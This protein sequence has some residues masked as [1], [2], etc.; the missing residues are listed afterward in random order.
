M[1]H[2]SVTSGDVTLTTAARDEAKVKRQTNIALLRRNTRALNGTGVKVC[3]LNCIRPTLLQKTR[4][5]YW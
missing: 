1:C 2:V 5:L 4:C 3:R